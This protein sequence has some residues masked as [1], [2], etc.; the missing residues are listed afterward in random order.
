MQRK[1]NPPD[2]DVPTPEQ[3]LLGIK[4]YYRVQVAEGLAA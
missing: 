1:T 3:K 4:K 2:M